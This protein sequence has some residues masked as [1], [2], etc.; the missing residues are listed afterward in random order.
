MS[1]TIGTI[2]TAGVMALGIGGLS[3]KDFSPTVFLLYFAVIVV[4]AA[5]S[6]AYGETVLSDKVKHLSR[7]WAGKFFGK[8]H[9]NQLMP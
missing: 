1:N 2:T 6:G 4:L 8:K 7:K 3:N 5:L 9:G